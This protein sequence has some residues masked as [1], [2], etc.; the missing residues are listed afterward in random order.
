[1]QISR[2]ISE[3]YAEDLPQGDLT[4]DNLGLTAKIGRA[5]LIAKEDLVLSGRQIFEDCIHHL[6]REI[7]LKWQFKDG[8]L[9]LNQQTVCTLKGDL[10]Q[11]LKAERVALNF[12][13]RL[14]GIATLTR[15]YVQETKGTKCR[16]LDTRKTTPLWR[17]LEKQAVLSGGGT[18]HRMN[19]SD[20]VLIKENHIRACGGLSEAIQSVR[21]RF[22]GPIE[23]ECSTLAEVNL[24]VA[25]KA[26]RILLDN[27]SLEDTRQ[28]R[29]LI[30]ASVEVEASGNMT[31]ERIRKVAETGV[32]FISVGALTHSAPN[33]DFSLL[34]EWKK[35]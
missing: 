9:V 3:A 10:L 1:M 6:D 31:V 20:A 8:D 22:S 34:F 33:A 7:E 2:M 30:P 26:S 16:I 35:I 17:A 11:L 32:N 4:T 29:R 25:A 5:R 19:L 27:M 21:E 14:S 28:A 15:C 23:A 13:G 18:N 12:L 24:A